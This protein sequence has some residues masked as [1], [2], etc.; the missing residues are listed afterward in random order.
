MISTASVMLAM[1]TVMP[2]FSCDHFNCFW[3]GNDPPKH[4]YVDLEIWSAGHW[5]ISNDRSD[6]ARLF[7]R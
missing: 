6:T 4:R 1:I 2:T 7:P 3:L 5:V